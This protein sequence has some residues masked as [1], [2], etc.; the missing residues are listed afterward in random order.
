MREGGLSD[1]IG[2][3]IKSVVIDGNNPSSPRDQVHFLFTDGT[4]FE[5]YGDSFTVGS[6]VTDYTEERVLELA[7]RRRGHVTHLKATHSKRT[8][9]K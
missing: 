7:G 1:I 3:T 4:A 6:H 8:Q 2:K 9:E 5:F